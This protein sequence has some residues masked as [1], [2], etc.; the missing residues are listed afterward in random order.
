M[1]VAS[2]IAPLTV[3]DYAA[4]TLI[5]VVRYAITGDPGSCASE[6]ELLQLAARWAADSV[7][8]VQ[9]RARHLDAGP[10]TGLARKLIAV[11]G[12]HTKLLVNGRADV[13]IAAAASGVHLTAAPGELTPQQVRRIFALAGRTEPTISVSCHTLEAAQR[14]RDAA[15]DLILFAPVFEK[16]I[17]G[18]LAVSGVGLETL[19]R[20]CEAVAPLQVLA[21][22]GVTPGS[23]QQCIDA[24][25]A[26]I[27]GIRLF[28]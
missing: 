21:L 1:C 25:A 18:A 14:A 15:A 24:G 12:P 19:H 2:I 27:A 20:I 7:N 11:L 6:A 9:L 26:G 13:A 4:D 23:A 28:S 22:G 10:L 5:H 16:R 8:F 17:D 3:S